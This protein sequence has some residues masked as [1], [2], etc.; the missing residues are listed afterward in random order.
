V[1]V[2]IRIVPVSETD[3]RNAGILVLNMDTVPPTP[4]EVLTVVSRSQALQTRNRVCE[5]WTEEPGVSSVE[6]EPL[7]AWVKDRYSV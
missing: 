2:E 5:R 7:P 6:S 1:K 4:L 3:D